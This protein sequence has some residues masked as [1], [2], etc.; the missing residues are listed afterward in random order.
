MTKYPVEQLK[1]IIFIHLFKI[2][3][4][5]FRFRV[6]RVNVGNISLNIFFIQMSKPTKV[7]VGRRDFFTVIA[8]NFHYWSLLKEPQIQC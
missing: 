7:R 3:G 8:F 5:E 4:L 1:K 2:E 6:T